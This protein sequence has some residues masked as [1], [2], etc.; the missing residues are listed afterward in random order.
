[1]T[2]APCLCL[3]RDLLRLIEA[4]G[5]TVTTQADAINSA[6]LVVVAI[7]RRFYDS[8]PLP[9]LTNKILIDVSNPDDA[10]RKRSV[11]LM[12]RL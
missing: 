6:E 1:M 12:S 10:V 7:S 8:L 9:L 11:S 3:D 5:A 2:L 4:T